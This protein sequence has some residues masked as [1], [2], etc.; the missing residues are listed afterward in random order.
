MIKRPDYLLSIIIPAYNNAAF[1]VETLSSLQ[2]GIT[3]EVEIIIIDDGSTDETH[4]CITHFFYEHPTPHVNYIY[5]HNKGVAIARNTGLEN[6]TGKYIAFIDSDDTISP[7][8]FNILLPYLRSQVYDI[9]EFNLTRKI[10]KLYG[11]NNNYVSKTRAEI[12]EFTGNNIEKLIPTFKASQWHL[13]TKIF[14]RNIIGNDRFEEHRRYEDIMFCPFQYFKCSKILKINNYL[15]Y[16]RL[17]TK[18]ITENIQ[19]SDAAHIFFAMKKMC[20]YISINSEKK[21]IAT[22]MVINCFLEGRK[23]LRK[24]KGYYCYEENMIK[25]IQYAL[26][27][28][29][30][31][32]VN[33]KI[34]FKM[35]YNNVDRFISSV[36]YHLQKACKRLISNRGNKYDN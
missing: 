34:L 31:K 10:E 35:K 27:C 18:S 7:E 2:K 25:D 3:D 29:D 33:S 17:N 6:A 28:C 9:V 36:R 30:K 11:Y 8:Y 14:H 4:K 26:A 32:V 13:V 21:T 16:Y 20:D 24:K 1:I 12:L 19:E 22:F 23:I 15:Y 5:Q